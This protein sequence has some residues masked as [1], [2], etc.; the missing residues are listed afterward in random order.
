VAVDG[1]DE[2]LR[3]PGRDD[4]V[5]RRVVGV[6]VLDA[7]GRRDPRPV[8]DVGRGV[9]LGAQGVLLARSADDVGPA[10]VVH[11]ETSLTRLD[12]RIV[13]HPDVV[14]PQSDQEDD[15]ERQQ[16]HV[17]QPGADAGVT[18]VDLGREQCGDGEHGRPPPPR[19]R[20]PFAMAPR[21]LRGV[22]PG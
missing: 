10:R 2:P 13:T 14:V 4:P 1:G 16:Q 19:H 15:G 7:H 3:V 11:R 17:G 21:A 6:E 22:C 18:H 5:G 8:Q 20:E 12:H 9:E